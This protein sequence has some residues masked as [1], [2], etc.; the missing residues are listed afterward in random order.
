MELVGLFIEAYSLEHMY[1]ACFMPSLKLPG[2]IS[3]YT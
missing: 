2:R 1:I 3:K